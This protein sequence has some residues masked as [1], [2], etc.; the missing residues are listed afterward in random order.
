VYFKEAFINF[1]EKQPTMRNP[2]YLANLWGVAISLCTMNAERVSVFEL[3]DV[4]SM[5]R[6]LKQY[7]WS[8]SGCKDEFLQTVTTSGPEGLDALC[9]LWTEYGE[10]L[11]KVLLACFQI[12]S[13]TGLDIDRQEF[14]AL[15][16]PPDTSLP[17]RV[18]LKLS[19]HSWI[20]FLRDTE[21]FFTVAVIVEESLAAKFGQH[22]RKC[23]KIDGPS[24]LQT[25]ICVGDGI[26]PSS[27]LIKRQ[28]TSNAREAQKWAWQW[29][30]S[31]LEVGTCFP[32]GAQG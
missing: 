25:S 4:P 12:L 29:D 7:P 14:G 19:E 18:L 22:R 9:N 2:R 1:W 17:K 15:W 26:E 13:C 8:A 11:G 27:Q 5:R 3:L 30:V 16:I 6:F 10:E 24:A 20:K 21:V 28:I 31:R 23:G 32:I